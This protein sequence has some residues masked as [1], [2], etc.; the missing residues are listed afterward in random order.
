MDRAWNGYTKIAWV[1]GIN[2]RSVLIGSGAMAAALLPRPL[3]SWQASAQ[4][5]TGDEASKRYLVIRRYRLAPG[6]AIAEVVQR[7]EQDFVPILRQVAGFVEY[8]NVDLGNGEGLTISVFSDEAGAEESTARAAT[9]VQAHLM[10]LV[11]GPPEVM[12]GSIVLNVTAQEA[13]N[14][15]AS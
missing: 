10:D 15:A 3:A 8:Y 13:A 11:A 12:Q 5:A 6:A 4:E 9:W 7:T 2:R 1:P 14:A